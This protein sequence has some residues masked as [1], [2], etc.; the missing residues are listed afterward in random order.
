MPRPV[1]LLLL[2]AT[3]LVGCG[4]SGS[5]SS[6]PEDLDSDRADGRGATQVAVLGD[7]IV[8]GSP[9]WDPDPAIREQI[10]PAL[11]ERSQFEYWASEARPELEFRNCG[12]FG[13]RTDEIAARVESCAEGADVL[14]V[15]GGI[16]DIAQGVDV[17]VAAGG[18]DSL[19]S[20]GQDLGL[21]VAI[22]DV[23]PWNNGF[24]SAAEPIEDLNLRIAEIGEN[25]GVP[26]L[27]FYET[28]EDPERPGLMREEWTDDGDHPSV[29]GYREL[30]ERAVLPQLPSP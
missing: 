16:N 11:D 26:V 6:G 3:L 22:A 9:L 10:G 2:T 17:D 21:E 25:R 8:A 18:I 4:G 20:A 24:P 23:L 12:V 5:P 15:Q 1:A 19:V 29:A 28:L 7:S 14:I 27:P 30:A 13:E